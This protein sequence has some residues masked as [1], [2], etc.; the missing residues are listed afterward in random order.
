MKTSILSILLSLFGLNIQAQSAVDSL[1][2]HFC[3]TLSTHNTAPQVIA[4]SYAKAM[5]RAEHDKALWTILRDNAED[6][7]HNPS[8]PH[9][10]DEIYIPLLDTFLS[11]RHASESDSLRYIFQ[12][13]RLMK[14]RVGS[15]AAD[16]KLHVTNNKS[17]TMLSTLCARC[18]TTLLLFYDPACHLCATTIKQMS[19]DTILQSA[20]LTGN[21]QVIAINIAPRRTLFSRLFKSKNKHHHT[22]PPHWIS[23]E[24]RHGQVM[25]KEIY[26]LPFT[27][28]VYT[29]GADM[30]V[31]RK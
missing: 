5:K 3:D 10:N 26:S 31:I 1:I 25:E 27:P 23:A 4:D 17:S 7:F 13:E 14:N 22:L 29:I 19:N 24:D 9:H 15:Q 20:C 16:L 18:D 28:Q 6:M 21:T 12:R 30:T 8:S 11:S 2:A